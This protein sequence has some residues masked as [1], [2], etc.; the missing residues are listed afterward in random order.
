MESRLETV[1]FRIGNKQNSENRHGTWAKS[2]FKGVRFYDVNNR[3]FNCPSQEKFYREHPWEAYIH[4]EKYESKLGY[5]ATAK[6][7][8]RAYDARARE[9]YGEFACLNFPEE[10]APKRVNRKAGRLKRS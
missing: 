1:V 5:Y 7:A 3:C 6:E 10:S 8:A 4:N 9:V 2:G